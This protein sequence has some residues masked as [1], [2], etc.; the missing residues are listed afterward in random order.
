MLLAPKARLHQGA[1][2]V[3]VPIVWVNPPL[4]VMRPRRGAIADMAARRLDDLTDA[5]AGGDDREVVLADAKLRPVVILS[6]YPELRRLREVRALP[7]YSY[8]PGSAAARLRPDIEAGRVGSAFHLA[9]NSRLGIHD[10]ALRLDQV[11][12]VDAGFLRQPAATLSD[13]ALAALL[14]H[15][16]RYVQAL[17]RRPVA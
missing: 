10:G 12:P 11:Q 3:R 2:Y 1:L 8:R 6:S 14:E 9:G 7:L 13:A 16:M 5:F 15:A 4:F 17:D